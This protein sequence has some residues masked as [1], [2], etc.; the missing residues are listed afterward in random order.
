[1]DPDDGHT[2]GVL[3]FA[4]ASGNEGGL[5]SIRASSPT[6]GGRI[7]VRKLPLNYEVRSFYVLTVNVTDNGCLGGSFVG[8]R[9]GSGTVTVMLTDINE[10]PDISDSNVSI[11]ENWNGHVGSALA[12]S[13][14][15]VYQHV[16]FT[17]T[18]VHRCPAPHV[19]G[20][21]ACVAIPADG[22]P[23]AFL[24]RSSQLVVSDPSQLDYEKW[25]YKVCVWLGNGTQLSS[26][27]C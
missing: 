1:M 23:F 13:N 7:T 17:V 20:G 24:A 19:V 26:I 22:R 15:E 27:L 4:I 18:N 5:F 9:T 2:R 25:T 14:P 16:V 11:V 6:E 8:R 10:Y 3:S 12:H 21:G